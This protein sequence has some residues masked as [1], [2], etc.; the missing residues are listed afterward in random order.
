MSLAVVS[1]DDD[2]DDDVA[3]DTGHLHFLLSFS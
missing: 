3:F 2:D 1:D